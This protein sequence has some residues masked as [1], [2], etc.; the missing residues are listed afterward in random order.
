M[1][2]YLKDLVGKSAEEI[3]K[4]F[5]RK[6]YLCGCG[7][8]M[9]G[10]YRISDKPVCEGCYYEAFGDFVEKNPICTPGVRRG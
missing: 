5:G 8:E 10:P 9:K 6:P 4:L 2:L 3:G 7:A 1:P